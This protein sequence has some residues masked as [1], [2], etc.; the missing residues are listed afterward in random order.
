MDTTTIRKTFLDFYRGRDHEVRPSSSLI[1]DDPTLLLTSAGM[2]QFKPYFEGKKQPPYRR[3]ASCQ[4]CF[5]TT[6]LEIVGTT[7]RHF[8]FFE[9]LG[10]FSFGDYFK[11]DAIKWAWELMTEHYRLDPDRLWATVYTTDDEAAEIWEKET[12]VPIDRIL[13]RGREGGNFWD[14]GVAG[15]CGPCSELLYD[16]GDDF[17]REYKP[18]EELDDERYL[19]IYNLVF[20]QNLQNDDGEIVGDLPQRNVDTGLGLARLGAVLQDVETSF[21]VDSMRPILAAAEAELGVEYK[22]NPETDVSLRVLGEHSRAVTFLIADGVVPSN[23]GRGYVLRR[24]VRRA[25]RYA[26]LAGV[27]RPVLLPLVDVTVDLFKDWYPE[28]GTNQDVVRR[29]VQREEDR[30]DVTLRQGLGSLEAEIEQAKARG[31]KTLSGSFAFRLHDT[32]GFP[33]DLTKDIAEEEGLSVD[34]VGFESEMA[35]QRNRARAAR[36][37]ADRIDAEMEL[38][39][40]LE[41]YG[42]TEFVG[43][44]RLTEDSSIAGLIVGSQPVP[45]IAEGDEGVVVLRKT[46]FYPEGGGQIGD[47]GEISTETGTFMVEETRWGV[48]GVVVHTGRVVEGEIIVDE[49]SSAD[50]DRTHREGVRQ[51]HTATHILHWHLRNSVGQHATQQGSRVEPGRLTFDFSHFEALDPEQ[52]AQLEEEMNHRVLFDDAVRAFETSYDFAMSIGA[53]ALFGEKYGDFVRVVEVGDYSKELCGGTHVAHT[54]QVGVIKLVGESSVGAGLRRVEA[55]TGLE[56]LRYLNRKAEELQR[57]SELLK[58]DPDHVAERLEKTLQT[59]KELESQVARQRHAA[60]RSE[61]EEILESP[62]VRQFGETRAVLLRR[63]G[64]TVPDMRNLAL[65]IRKRLGS[66]VVVIGSAQNGSANLVAA[67]SPDLTERG[68][69]AQSLIQEAASA[70]GGRSGGKPDLAIAGG[71]NASEIDRAMALA[72]RAVANA[73]QRPGQAQF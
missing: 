71:R 66:G 37:G 65:D 49:D 70:L 2:V 15:P 18:G 55:L 25:V 51:S 7:S 42:R 44:E 43:Y 52:L 59:L 69:S 39:P 5:R 40:V 16:R 31:D 32:Y 17:G 41:R 72:E 64:K 29:V 56:G 19:E 24:L 34:V 10:N 63:D 26:R 62:E 36:K 27:D 6:D 73:L 21:D 67:S 45:I 13:R 4:K 9:M 1:P 54:G 50:V 28:I 30:F 23:E 48:P 46:P 60:Q 20:M 58:V 33:L 47:K 57:A 53:T 3:A 68:V 22:S 38:A 12:P 8:T 14:M 11:P 35:A 61:V